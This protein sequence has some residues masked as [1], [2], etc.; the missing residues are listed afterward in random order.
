MPLC[1]PART[2]IDGTWLVLPAGTKESSLYCVPGREAVAAPGPFL[3]CLLDLGDAPHC[4]HSWAK[5]PAGH[6]RGVLQLELW[7]FPLLAFAHWG[8]GLLLPGRKRGQTKFSC[9]FKE[10]GIPLTCC[11]DFAEVLFDIFVLF[12]RPGECFRLEGLN[13]RF[14][15]PSGLLSIRTP[16]KK[17]KDSGSKPLP[18]NGLL[19][20]APLCWGGCASSRLG[21]R[22]PG[23]PHPQDKSLPCSLT[24]SY[25]PPCPVYI[26]F[27]GPPLSF[28]LSFAAAPFLP[29][30]FHPSFLHLDL[31]TLCFCPNN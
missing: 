18:A 8:G 21:D 12:L 14:S 7:S 6:Q 26:L 30:L 11:L 17:H 16:E 19:P 28:H 13:E 4:H 9:P 24:F 3:P 20:T 29:S 10:L 23:S 5:L 25:L 1:S 15:T 27:L 2:S 31:S 22:N